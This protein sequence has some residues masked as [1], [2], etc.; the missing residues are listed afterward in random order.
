MER[1]VLALLHDRV[2]V[3][4]GKPGV[5][6]YMLC[7]QRLERAGGA[8]D[9]WENAARYLWKRYRLPQG[10]V[11]LVLPGTLSSIRI[12]SLPP[13]RRGRLARAVQDEMQ[14]RGEQALVA[15][16]VPIGREASGMWRVLACSCLR[17]DLRR[18]IDMIERLGLGTAGITVPVEPVFK[19][20]RDT[21]EIRTRSCIL[22]FFDGS[23]LLSILTERGVCRY[24]AYSLLQD[25]AGAADDAGG[26]I[27][28]VSEILRFRA[29]QDMNA[30]L[31][32]IY[33]AGCAG[34]DF[35]ACVPGL[36]KLGFQA[37][38]LPRC[39]RIRQFPAGERMG[40]WLMCAG[41]MLR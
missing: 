35:R 23:A 15:G 28:H 38:P 13:M 30:P 12:F 17:E 29:V 3:G 7:Q 37:V 19:L 2:Q 4:V 6:V 25:E 40:D 22:L 24:A 14:Y 21:H 9:E 26:I 31:S 34:G 18:L 33:Y 39:E 27:G 10:R 8:A 36:R 11:F 20:V 5:G 16:Y 1:I 41:G 32:C